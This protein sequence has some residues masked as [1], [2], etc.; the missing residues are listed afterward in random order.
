MAY[1]IVLPFFTILL[2]VLQRTLLDLLFGGR[3]GVEMSLLLVIY[4][5]FHLDMV[6]GGFLAFLAGFLLDC[7]SGTIM[8]LYTFI[9]VLIFI[10][11]Y[12]LSPR[13]YGERMFF[14]MGYAFLCVLLEGLF[15]FAVYWSVYGT[16]V[17]QGLLRTYLPQALVAGVLSPALFALFNR[18]EVYVHAGEA[19]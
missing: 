18:L 3:I 11:S 15:I 2:I 10:L 6:R 7:V 5:G 17:S 14:I 8:G 19:R 16:D 4:A 12:L 9:Y 13:I 1:Y